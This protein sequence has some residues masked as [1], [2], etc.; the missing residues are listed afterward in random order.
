M[1][2][3]ANTALELPGLQAGEPFAASQERGVISVWNLK[4][5]SLYST[6]ACNL[7]GR[8]YDKMHH[9]D[10]RGRALNSCHVSPE[11][12]AASSVNFITAETCSIIKQ[13]HTPPLNSLGGS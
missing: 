9:S 5:S 10:K 3:R 13:L 11:Q 6:P 4:P 7:G 8:D 1:D 2:P 12:K